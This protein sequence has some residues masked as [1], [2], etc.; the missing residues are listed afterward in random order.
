MSKRKKGAKIGYVNRWPEWG[1]IKGGHVGAFQPGRVF[2]AQQG[3]GPVSLCFGRRWKKNRP[4]D[5]F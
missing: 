2:E 4:I 1:N 5:S 3:G